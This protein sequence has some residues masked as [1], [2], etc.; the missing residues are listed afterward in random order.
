MCIRDRDEL[1]SCLD[2]DRWLWR[3]HLDLPDSKVSSIGVLL[4][5]LA[6]AVCCLHCPNTVLLTLPSGAPV[7]PD[8]IGDCLAKVGEVGI[9]L[10]SSSSSFV[11]VHFEL[12]PGKFIAPELLTV[13]PQLVTVKDSRE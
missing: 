6:F 13:S 7:P 9:R 11:W 3:E 5:R 4:F 12:V 10:S 1:P 8:S 2:L